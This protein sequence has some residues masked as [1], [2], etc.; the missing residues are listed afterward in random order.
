MK[1]VILLFL[2]LCM[3]LVMG[4]GSVVPPGKTVILL[5]PNGSTD[6]KTKG[7]YKAWGRTK[8]YFV[9][10]RLK[11]FPETMKVL[12]ADDINMDIDTKIL[13]SFDVSKES[14]DF[15]KSKVP[16]K[17]VKQGDISGY[18]LSLEEFYTLAVRDVHRGTVRSVASAYITDD[19][20]PNRKTIEAEV[21]KQIVSR[22]KQLAYPL[23]VSGVL[24]SNIDYPQAV[25]DMRT[26]I[27]KV[28]LEEQRKDAQ[29]KAD[30]AEARRRVQVAQ[31]QAKERLVLAQAQ[32]D[33]NKILTESLDERFL[34]WRQF[35]VMEAIAEKLGNGGN[36][37]VFMMPYEMMGPGTMGAAIIKQSV[38]STKT[39]TQ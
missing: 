18:E 16:T 13:L 12:M 4:C 21:Q 1:K 22:I 34:R 32:A 19:V 26:E 38:D 7:V 10:G 31:E 9:D 27:K 17:R 37:T 5:H 36:N 24:L 23:Q 15:I 11:S 20:R 30:I 33:Q 14:I 35:E 6:I 28:Q 39:K 3:F 2:A 25:K 29:A 8:V